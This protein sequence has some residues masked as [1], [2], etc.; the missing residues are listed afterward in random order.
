MT[1]P[2]L[3]PARIIAAFGRSYL[4]DTG[5][6]APLPCVAR[7]KRSEVVCGDQVLLRLGQDPAVIETLLPRRNALWRQDAWRSKM[8]AANLDLVLVVTSAEPTPNLELVG[9]ALIA[10][11]SED[12]PS[13]LVLNKCE[14]AGT[15]RLREMLQPLQLAGYPL[16]EISA[17]QAPEDAA[18]ILREKLDGRIGM[19]IGASGVGKSTL[20]NALVPGLRAQTQTISTALNAGRHT[21][22][23]T[24]L[25]ML[26]GLAPGSGLLD[27]PGFQAFGLNQLSVTQLQHAFPEIAQRNGT[28][29]FNNCTHRQEPGCAV[30]AAVDAGEFAPSRYALYLRVLQELLDETESR[31]TA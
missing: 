28:C 12:I 23:A 15:Q 22:T 10:A 1:D 27:S 3:Q 17:R 11:Q 7:G 8:F 4:A 24:R 26:E 29:R 16:I 5:Q 20:A 31:T 21:T 25:Y 19:L 9:R 14:L 18:R 6:G 2:S 13:S 30:R